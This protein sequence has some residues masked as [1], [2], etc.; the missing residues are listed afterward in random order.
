MGRFRKYLKTQHRLINGLARLNPATVA[1]AV[2]QG[3]RLF[4]VC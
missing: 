1:Q 2:L 3:V 4:L